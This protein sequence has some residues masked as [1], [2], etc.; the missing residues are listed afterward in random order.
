MEE[1]R[2][3]LER[4]GKANGVEKA[5]VLQSF[6]K[7]GDGEYGQGDRFYG[8]TVPQLRGYLKQSAMARGD[9]EGF[10]RMLG[11]MLED[12]Y[13][14]MRLLALL[15]LAER[16]R[17]FPQEAERAYRFYRAHAERINNWDL[18]DLSAPE[19]VGEWLLEKGDWGDLREMAESGHLWSQ[20]IAMVATFA[21]LKAG[22]SEP[23]YVLADMLLRHPHD[24]IRKAVGWMLREAGK[25][26]DFEELCRYL[27]SSPSEVCFT[28]RDGAG[29]V[30]DAGSDL[31]GNGR[32]GKMAVSGGVLRDVAAEPGVPRFRQMPRTMLRYAVERFPEALRRR[33]LGR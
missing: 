11:R 25:R 33:F 6:F 1:I 16:V 2:S 21:F 10:Y 27:E 24:L 12:A 13:H 8:V 28:E 29:I 18:V 32:G 3:F 4:A 22:L 23:T 30:P 14:E 7:T 17:L 5:R 26:V 31:A 9:A 15:A 20:R 19:V